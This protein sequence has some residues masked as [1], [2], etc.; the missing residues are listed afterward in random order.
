MVDDGMNDEGGVIQS[1]IRDDRRYATTT[2]ID[3]PGC[4]NEEGVVAMFVVLVRSS[5]IQ[6]IPPQQNR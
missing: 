6:E 4:A 5:N 2:P 1:S 3:G